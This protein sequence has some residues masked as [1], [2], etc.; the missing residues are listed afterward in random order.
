MPSCKRSHLKISMPTRR[1]ANK[2]RARRGSS[3]KT[4]RGGVE[5]FPSLRFNDNKR[6]AEVKYLDF[7]DSLSLADSQANAILLNGCIQG[8]DAVGDRVGRKIMMR[9][10][11]V[12]ATISVSAASLAVAGVYPNTTNTIRVLLVYDKQTNATV[13][14]YS[15][16]MNTSGNTNA[17]FANTNVSNVDRFM[18]LESRLFTLDTA[19]ALSHSFEFNL[20]VELVVRFNA[21]NNGNVTDIITGAMALTFVDQNSTGTMSTSIIFNSRIEFMDE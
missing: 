20:P 1:H 16:V 4:G 17:V 21:S 6:V 10:V 9:R 3:H 19:K 7:A 2:P 12:R 18:I 13:F 14:G 8:L 15:D 11:I 5:S